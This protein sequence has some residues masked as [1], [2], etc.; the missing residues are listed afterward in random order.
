[1][2]QEQEQEKEQERSRYRSNEETQTPHKFSTILNYENE[3][4]Y[5]LLFEGI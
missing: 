1:M 2:E 3:R 5:D 4:F